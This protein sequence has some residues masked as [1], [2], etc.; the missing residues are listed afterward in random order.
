VE[1]GRLLVEGQSHP[2]RFLKGGFQKKGGHNR[3]ESYAEKAFPDNYTAEAIAVLKAM[4]ISNLSNFVL[5][6][7]ASLRSQQY[8]GDFDGMDSSSDNG[9][10][11]KLKDIVRNVKGLKD[12]YISETKIGE[13]P[14][15]NVFRRTARLEGNKIVDFNMAESKGVVDKLKAA[16]II[17]PKEASDANDL[18]DKATTPIGFINAKKEIRFHI[19]RWMPIDIL[20]GFLEYRHHRFDLNEAI[21]SGGLIKFDVISN[22][23]DRFTEFSVIYNIYKGKKLIT[24]N[25]S[26]IIES[27]KEDIVFYEPKNPFKA[28][29]RFFALAKAHKEHSKA[30]ELVHLLNSDLGRLYQIIGDL[31]TLQRLL[32]MKKGSEADIRQQI[33]DMRSRL[34]NIYEMK[35]FLKQEH[36]IIGSIIAITKS[37]VSTM[38]GK[39]DKL[40]DAL[41]VILNKA[42]VKEVKHIDKKL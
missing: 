5:V 24:Q 20:N 40:I 8:A 37:P 28:L 33:D 27:L 17:N 34:G 22:Q 9:I 26:S 41:K 35:D 15:W 14:E 3:M 10:V 39:L 30:D 11:E 21:H 16:N 38:V 7:S 2:P 12:C 42:T 4:S 32:E 18:L 29:K 36:S 25:A 31:S 23:A 6:G 19:L 1:G 13:A